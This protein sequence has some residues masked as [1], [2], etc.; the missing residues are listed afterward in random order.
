M[1]QIQNRSM[2]IK[3]GNFC[4]ELECLLYT[5]REEKD[6]I[7]TL[8]SSNYAITPIAQSGKNKGGVVDPKFK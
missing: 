8:I 4:V 3:Y 7:G 6:R 5:I 1:D 2:L